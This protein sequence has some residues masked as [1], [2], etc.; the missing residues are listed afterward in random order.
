MFT[1]VM[2]FLHDVDTSLYNI[3]PQPVACPTAVLPTCTISIRRFS[4]VATG[5]GAFVLKVER[6]LLNK[7][8]PRHLHFTQADL[9]LP[10]LPDLLDYPYSV[11][12]AIGT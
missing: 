12:I 10:S 7:G 8:V 6:S 9:Y 4:R 11:P 1:S 5:D 2:L 3:V